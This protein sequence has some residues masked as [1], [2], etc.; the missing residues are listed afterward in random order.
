MR[1]LLIPVSMFVAVTGVLTACSEERLSKPEYEQL[2]RSSYADVQRA[3]R[4][5][6]VPSLELLGRRVA[7]AQAELRRSADRLADAEPP[8]EVE[9][10]NEELVEGLRDYAEQLDELRGA[11]ARGDRVAIRRFNSSIANNEAIGRIA[12]AAEEMKHKGY[13]LGP[14]AEE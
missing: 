6:N 14:I 4:A 11:I 5:T 7:A 2:V 13:D 8:A 10:E 1:S 3:F 12:E 9:E